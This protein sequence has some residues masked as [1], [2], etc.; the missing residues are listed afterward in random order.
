MESLMAEK[1]GEAQK[2]IHIGEDWRHSFSGLA[3]I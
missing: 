2:Q 1:N 3:E